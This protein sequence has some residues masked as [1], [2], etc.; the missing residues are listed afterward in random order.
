MPVS[1]IIPTKDEERNLLSTLSSL[2]WADQIFVFDSYSGDATVAIATSHGCEVTQRTFDNFADHKNWALDNLPFRNDWI[3]ILDADEKVLPELAAEVRDI[4][5]NGTCDAYYVARQIWVDGVW[6][7]YAGKYPDYQ[8]RLFRKGQARYEPRLVHEHMLTRGRVGYLAHPLWH[9]D[10]KGVAR[11]VDRHN[12]FAQMEAVEAY[13]AMRLPAGDK[14]ELAGQGW[15]Q[16]RRR[17]K[18]FA[19]RYLP[20]RPG[21]VFIYLY[22][23]KLGFLMGRVGLKTCML[24]MFYEYLIDLYL[25][26]LADPG[27]PTTLAYREYIARRCAPAPPNLGGGAS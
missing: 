5:R 7:K 20:F 11:Y 3:L 16:Q 17:L 18:N 2:T 6:L 25:E 8:M 14:D 13:I 24:R 10:N 22:V 26:E 27:S 19:Y 23:F 1:V 21:L 12:R 9:V 4:C 15:V